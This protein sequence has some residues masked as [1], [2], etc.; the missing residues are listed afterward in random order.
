MAA[1]VT[2]S[3]RRRLLLGHRRSGAVAGRL[4]PDLVFADRGRIVTDCDDV[5]FVLLAA[6]GL[7]DLARPPRPFTAREE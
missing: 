4:R 7:G 6:L 1:V 2:L 3:W 5:R